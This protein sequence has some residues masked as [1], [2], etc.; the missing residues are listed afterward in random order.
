MG[1]LTVPLS[2]RVIGW[3]ATVV[4]GAVA[5]VMIIQVIGLDL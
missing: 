5:A 1:K 2:V 4:M 3:L